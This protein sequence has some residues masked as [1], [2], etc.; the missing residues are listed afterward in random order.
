[1]VHLVGDDFGAE[2]LVFGFELDE[3]F[4]ELFFF[5][6]EKIQILLFYLEFLTE[7]FAL[8]VFHLE[9]SLHSLD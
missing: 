4:V 6:V 9:F 5:F 8:L 7:N 3:S 1:M 2:V